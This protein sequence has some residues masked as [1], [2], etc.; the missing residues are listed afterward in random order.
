[1]KTKYL[2][3]IASAL[4]VSSCVDTV[5][6]PDDLTV[7]EDFWVSKD[8]VALMVNGAYK[9]MLDENLITRLTMWG[10]L[11][12]DEVLPVVVDNSSIN[13]AMQQINTAN[14][15][16]TN[17]YADWATLYSVIN[18]CNIVLR[19]APGVIG[20]DPYYTQGDLNVDR[21]Q[22]LALRSLCY[23]YLVRNFRDVPYST[24]AFLESSQEMNLPQT[25][26]LT[27]IDGC[28]RD[29]QEAE[30]LALESNAFTGW[31]RVGWINKDA[32]RAMLADIYL[33]RASVMH[34][35][36]DY[37]ACVNYCNL[38]INSR[39]ASYHPGRTDTPPLNY[40][41]G[42]LT[43]E[44][45]PI[46]FGEQAWNTIFVTQNSEESIFEL[47][48]DGSKNSNLGL[49]KC[50]WKWKDNNSGNGLLKAS[51]IFSGF[52][53]AVAYKSSYDQRRAANVYGF[54]TVSDDGFD[55]R[56]F[57]DNQGGQVGDPT[58]N[59]KGFERTKNGRTQGAY[60]QN[61]IVYRLTDVMLMKAEAMVA[62]CPDIKEGMTHSDSISLRSAFNIVQYVNARSIYSDKLGSDSLKWG[63]AGIPKADLEQEI[64]KERLR[65]LCFEGKRWYDLLR[66]NYRHATGVRY[67]VILADQGG[68]YARVYNEMLQLMARKGGA[69]SG[70]LQS[71]MRTE[72]YLYM[73]VIQSQIECNPN[74]KQN[75]VYSSGDIWEKNV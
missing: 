18:N 4:L 29:L 70:A 65:E 5:I 30:G 11:R 19:K 32:I 74:L 25:A 22:M 53:D 37:Q 58:A 55:I 26:P 50:Y 69:G 35:N 64:L 9:G 21:S 34:N 41:A 66:F 51:S 3:I 61:Y 63:K 49:S 16:T 54:G 48:F 72:P 23:F 46:A 28:I 40:V 15:Q 10:D 38:I 31:K 7:D 62:Q 44:W 17:I 60:K 75:P 27:V 20:T 42:D 8:N 57:T 2:S 1:M 56:K 71:K 14:I 68:N 12:S 67:D 73:P 24:D 52:G 43:A 6:L 39:K 59:S 36:A 33:W 45:Y 47:Q 13:D